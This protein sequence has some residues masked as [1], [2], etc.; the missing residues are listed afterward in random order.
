MSPLKWRG[1]P[2][3]FLLETTEVSSAQGAEQETQ[4][5]KGP[6]TSAECGLFNMGEPQ[7]MAMLVGIRRNH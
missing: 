7:T 1:F 5:L 4:R 6:P 3:F 2:N